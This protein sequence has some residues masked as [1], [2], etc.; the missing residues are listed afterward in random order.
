MLQR[1][2]YYGKMDSMMLVPKE[3]YPELWRFAAEAGHAVGYDKPCILEALGVVL[4]GGLS[5]DCRRNFL[6]DAFGFIGRESFMECPMGAF[7]KLLI[8]GAA[9]VAGW[10]FLAPGVPDAEPLPAAVMLRTLARAVGIP[11]NT[12]TPEAIPRH[13]PLTLGNEQARKLR[14]FAAEHDLSEAAALAVVLH[15]GLRAGRNLLTPDESSTGA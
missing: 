12:D 7:T 14:A 8:E 3:Y 6:H 13:Y 5:P 1:F 9:D 2:Q 4:D 10:G 15:I 11:A